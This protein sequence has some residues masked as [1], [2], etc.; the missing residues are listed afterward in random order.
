MQRKGLLVRFLRE[1]FE[2]LPARSWRDARNAHLRSASKTTT[3]AMGVG[4]K[5]DRVEDAK[6]QKKSSLTSIFRRG[7]DLWPSELD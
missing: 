3:V 1:D 2:N 6:I 7:F 5:I 4:R